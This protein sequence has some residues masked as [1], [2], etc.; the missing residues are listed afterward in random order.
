MC[1]SKSGASLGSA[2]L[3][4]L[5]ISSLHAL[6]ILPPRA[7]RAVKSYISWIISSRHVHVVITSFYSCRSLASFSPGVHTFMASAILQYLTRLFSVYFSS[8][9]PRAQVRAQWDAT[10]HPATVRH[11]LAGGAICNGTRE[12]TIKARSIVHIATVSTQQRDKTGWRNISR[13][14]IQVSCPPR[15]VTWHLMFIK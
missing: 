5:W 3:N 8:R 13:K 9:W 6:F 1:S 14:A 11:T 7:S 12:N 4:P 2:N 10:S 15:A